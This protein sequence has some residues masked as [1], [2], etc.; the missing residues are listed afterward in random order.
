MADSI[1]APV[2]RFPP[3]QEAQF[4]EMRKRA[5]AEINAQTFWLVALLVLGFSWWDWYVDPPNWWPAFLL[6]CL[7]A[8]VILATGL[9][10]RITRRV[11]LAPLLSKIRFPAAVVPVGAA[12]AGLGRGRRV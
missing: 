4:R 2:K 10:Q 7:G 3:E 9:V 12:L 6:R 8:V 1:P 5:L 11:E